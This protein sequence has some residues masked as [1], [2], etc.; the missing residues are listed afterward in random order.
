[1]SSR[2]EDRETGLGLDN[3]IS[4]EIEEF[5]SGFHTSLFDVNEKFLKPLYRVE[6]TQDEVKVVFDL[7]FV[8]RKKD[9]SLS[10]TEAALTI[11]AKTS[12]PI[13]LMV[14]GPYQ[15]KVEFERYCATI[16][17]PRT[18]NPVRARARFS[19]GILVVTFPLPRSKRVIKIV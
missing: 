10:S 6:V 1:L 18:V 3:A 8:T 2:D 5:F 17:L 4:Q 16:D 11:E 7:P 14:G 15:K 9:L 13:S 12:K 19:K